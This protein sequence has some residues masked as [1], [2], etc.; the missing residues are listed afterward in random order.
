VNNRLDRSIT[1]L[2]VAPTIRNS[3]G[4]PSIGAVALHGALVREDTSCRLV[5]AAYELGVGR[6]LLPAREI[7]PPSVNR[8]EFRA[9]RPYRAMASLGLFREIWR[10][11]RLANLVH[12]HGQYLSPHVVAFLTARIYGTPYGVQAHGTLEPY[13][14][15][16]S[17][18][19]KALFN[20]LIGRRILRGAAYVHFATEIE[21]DHAADVVR[22]D[23]AWVHSLGATLSETPRRPVR[24]EADVEGSP[25]VS[26]VGRLAAKKRPD[27]LI[28]A[29]A[30]ARRPSSARLVIAGPDEAFTEK[31]LRQ[32]AERL[33]VGD[34][35]V[36]IGEV[37]LHE[38]T[39]LFGHSDIFVLP[40][41]NENFGITVG[42][43]MSAGCH[44]IVTAHVAAS[45][46]LERARSG[47]VI[48]EAE[49][50]ALAVALDEAFER[51]EFVTDS[52]K[53]A[54]SYAKR[55]LNWDGMAKA[56]LTFA[57]FGAQS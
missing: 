37:N 12:L 27:L 50:G 15:A 28:E 52:G 39:W 17:P 34:S 19:R 13:Q 36:A 42:E 32:L 54:Q 6:R 44:V 20:W 18:R 14:R 43:A 49:M 24:L 5:S 11:V 46:H 3:H 4:G 29:W 9:S 55:H 38:K 53:R 31:Q 56:L 48:P 45:H 25:L 16:I 33:G 22:V 41:E 47:R 51:P 57:H 8:Y 7:N 21:A 1:V 10:S 30:R 23:Q 2:Q 26:F 35:V 40:S